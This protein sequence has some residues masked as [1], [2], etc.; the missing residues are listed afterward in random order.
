MIS[1]SD[2]VNKLK[3]APIYEFGPFRLVPAER[4]LLCDGQAVALPPKA[5]DILVKRS[6]R[7]VTKDELLR[8][9]WPDSFVEESNLSHNISVLRKAL[10][11]G[12]GINGDGYIETI[13]GY[14]FR[15]RADVHASEIDHTAVVVHRRT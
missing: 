10:G 14:G 5:F 9:V 1:E 4:Q 12:N 15:F 11:N 3:L 13:R 6:G 7:V 2:S 8:E